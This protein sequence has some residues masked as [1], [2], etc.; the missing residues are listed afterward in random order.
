LRQ[1]TGGITAVSGILAAGINCGIKSQN[2]DLALVVSRKPATVAA[3]FTTNEAKAAPVQLCQQ[4]LAAGL[5]QAVI[6]NSGNANAGTGAKGMADGRRMAELTAKGLGIDPGLVW[7]ASTGIIG[8]P[9]PMDKIAAG[10]QGLIPQLDSSGGEAAAEAILTTDTRPKQLAVKLSLEAGEV[11]LGGMAKGA[12]MIRPKLA[13]MLCFL[14]TDAK[15]EPAHLQSALKLAVEQSFNLITI[16]GDTSTNDMVML[17]ATGEGV[18]LDPGG[19]D[20]EAFEEGLMYL[21]RELAY[22]LVWDAEGATKLI[23]VQVAQGRD[24]E[25]ARRVAFAIAD[26]NLVKCA[27]FGQH[28]NWG[29]ILAA[30]GYAEA[31]IDPRRLD[32]YIG[33]V[34][35]VEGGAKS[36][37]ADEAQAQA[38][39][40]RREITVRLTLG[41]GNSTVEVLTCDFSADYVKINAHY[42]T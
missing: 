23:R 2:K 30:A 34:K 16:D 35:L 3:M 31:G 37:G 26:S 18:T 9:L 36:A 8:A 21:T 33:G 10:I 40:A 13:T 7:V 38:E 15:I 27:F 6:I 25:Q 4:R 19:R 5:A 29:R 28:L 17:L 12:G 11:I 14:A 1:I 39:L 41:Q 24:K 32:I 42:Q 22:Q 20:W